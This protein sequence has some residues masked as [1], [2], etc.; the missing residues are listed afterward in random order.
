MAS[1]LSVRD[2]DD[3]GFQRKEWTVERVGWAV[4]ALFLAAALTGLF[5]MG[6][7][8]ETTA[9]APDDTITVEYDRFIRNVGTS[10]MTIAVDDSTVQNQ[11][12]TLF[13]SREL[14]DGLRI[15]GV[16]PAPSTESSSRQ[17]L[18]Y[19]FDVLGETAPVIEILY[20]GGGIGLRDGIIRAGQGAGVDLWQLTYP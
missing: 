16:T 5:G 14:A 19:E 4:I 1:S 18:I 12:V 3:I 20:R 15:Q 7:V 10:A 8:S 9:T 2:L 6:P 13:I 11:K 17:G